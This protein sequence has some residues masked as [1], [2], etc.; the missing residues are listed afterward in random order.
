MTGES[1]TDGASVSPHPTSGLFKSRKLTNILIAVS[2]WLIFTSSRSTNAM[3]WSSFRTLCDS[4]CLLMFMI[5]FLSVLKLFFFIIQ[6]KTATQCQFM[7]RMQRKLLL[8]SYATWER[9]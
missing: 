5:G 4:S 1:C 8:I 2:L 9:I 6:Y 3:F 7:L